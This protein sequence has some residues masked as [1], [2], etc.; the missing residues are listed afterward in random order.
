MEAVMDPTAR[1]DILVVVDKERRS[2]L[3]EMAKVLEAKGLKV[4]DKIPRARAILGSADSSQ[5]DALRSVQGVELVRP[6]HKLQLPPMDE[7]IPQ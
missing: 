6:Q 1:I 4:Q 7:N 5:V 3:D 2:S